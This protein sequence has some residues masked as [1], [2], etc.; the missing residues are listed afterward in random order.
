MI[1]DDDFGARYIRRSLR[2]PWCGSNSCRSHYRR[3]RSNW[4]DLAVIARSLE[5]SDRP[6]EMT[7]RKRRWRPSDC[8]RNTFAFENRPR[9]G[10][11]VAHDGRSWW[12]AWTE[13]W[14]TCRF[15]EHASNAAWPVYEYIILKSVPHYWRA[16]K[17]YLC[18]WPSVRLHVSTVPKFVH[19]TLRTML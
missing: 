14:F 15:S 13:G 9:R 7:V 19:S 4:L 10:L 5:T 18:W 12:H 3:I 16:L 8:G 2:S 17:K 11:S 6:S 1:I